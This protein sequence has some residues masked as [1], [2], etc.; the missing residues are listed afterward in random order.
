MEDINEKK[1]ER[2]KQTVADLKREL[3][4][5]IVT[6]WYTKKDGTKRRARGTLKDS[7]IP[8]EDAE[9]DRKDNTTKGVLNYYD[10]DKDDWRCMI[11]D[12]FIRYKEK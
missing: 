2:R 5:G 9:D 1:T 3:K 6:F 11:K 7:L 10:L 12:N 4:K 8:K